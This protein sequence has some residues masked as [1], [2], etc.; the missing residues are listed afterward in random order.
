MIDELLER[1]VRDRNDAQDL[2]R[3]AREKEDQGE[4]D[5][6]FADAASRFQNV[7]SDLERG[8]RTVR[9]QQEPYTRDVCR[10]L[11]ALSQTY[12]SFGGT[13]RDAG[14]LLRAE[15]QYMKGNEYEEER[16]RNCAAKDTYNML[17]LLIVRLLIE[18]AR[19]RQ[20]DFV[21]DLKAVRDELERQV[22]AGRNDSWA[23]ADLT[24]SRILCGDEDDSE[25]K[26]IEQ[27]NASAAF[28]ESTYNA[29]AALVNEGLARGDALGDR[30]ES[31]KRLLQRKGG[32]R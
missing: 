22:E 16:R 26:K 23:L 12:G 18:P 9:R 6:L 17:Q 19:I 31:F 13:W 24:L 27:G 28:Y 1:A 8:L 25:F 20:A 30:L 32:I 2:R 21:A 3:K 5:Q 15:E 7:I 14:D 10:I 11:E 4:R 29:I